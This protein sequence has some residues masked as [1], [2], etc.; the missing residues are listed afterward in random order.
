MFLL[1][2]AENFL[3]GILHDFHSCFLTAVVLVVVLV[4]VLANG[5][6]VRIKENR[7][8]AV[9]R[10]ESIRNSEQFSIWPK[11]PLRLKR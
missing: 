6:S 9:I 11:T 7:I 2:S 5:T 10:L 1:A 4:V 8:G 3:D